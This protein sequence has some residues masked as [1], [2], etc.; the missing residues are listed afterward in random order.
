MIHCIH[1]VPT[2]YFQDSSQAMVEETVL[3][4]SWKRDKHKYWTNIGEDN[5]PTRVKNTL[6]NL[7]CHKYGVWGAW[8]CAWS[9]LSKRGLPLERNVK[10]ILGLGNE[11]QLCWLIKFA[12]SLSEI[13][14]TI[15]D[16]FYNCNRLKTFASTKIHPTIKPQLLF[17]KLVLL[18]VRLLVLL[19]KCITKEDSFTKSIGWP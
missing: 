9:Y 6:G 1:Y 19:S 14:L 15:G 4:F 8:R 10:L 17:Y 13:C 12:K 2:N 18:A 16:T 3:K 7:P 11:V 5:T